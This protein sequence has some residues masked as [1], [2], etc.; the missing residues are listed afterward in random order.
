MEFDISYTNQ[1]ITPWGGMVFLRQMLDKIG[2]KMQVESCL[3]LPQPGSNRG[4]LPSSIIESFLV[5]IWCGANRFMHTE[6]TRHDEALKKIFGWK[7]S[8]AQDVYKR[9]FAKFTQVI[10]QRVSDHFYSWIFNSIQFDNY[11]LDCDS[12]VLTR[13]GEQQGAKRGYNPHKPGRASHNPIIAFV[14]DVK[15]VANLWMRSGNTGS[16]E[17]FIPFLEDTFTKLQGKNISLLRLD[18][19][20]FGKEVFD[21]LEAKVMPINY[22]VAARFYEPIQRI[23]AGNQVWTTLDEGIEISELQYKGQLWNKP[24]RMIVVRQ[25]IEKRPKSAGKTLKLFQDEDYYRQYRYS[26]YITNLTLSAADVW[27]LYRGRGDAENR[28]KELKYDFGFD[29]F[30]MQSFFG[31]EATLIFAMLAYNLMA[32]FRQFLLN[33]KVQHT[34]STLRYKTFAIGAYFQK[35]NNKY[36]LKLSLNMKRREWF[37][38]LWNH[39]NQVNLPFK[40]SNA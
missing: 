6:V 15:L 4:Y 20:F 36:T 31:T 17:G 13:Y 40:F 16:A 9:Y 38:G 8:P 10:N 21:Y 25:K 26:A 22:I 24:R 29:S 19:G 3:D 37:E 27:R 2:F 34:L 7:Q 11:T 32:L 35:I 1:E 14:S 12:S 30:N 39:S 18:S 28:I 23:I 5:S 33:S